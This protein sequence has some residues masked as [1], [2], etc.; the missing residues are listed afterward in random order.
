MGTVLQN[1]LAG[2]AF[3]GDKGMKAKRRS[4]LDEMEATHN[5]VTRKAAA[6]RAWLQ[7][8]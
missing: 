4:T 1:Q 7:A 2:G 8:H 6:K 5:G 3:M